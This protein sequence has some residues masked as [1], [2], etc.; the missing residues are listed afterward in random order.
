MS[1]FK[2]LGKEWKSKAIWEQKAKAII[3]DADPTEIG[4]KL[5]TL[6]SC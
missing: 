2:I 4:F 5:Y 3:G 6:P 1:R